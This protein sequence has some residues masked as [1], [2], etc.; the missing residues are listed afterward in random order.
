MSDEDDQKAGFA[1]EIGEVRRRAMES[2]HLFDLVSSM[3]SDAKRA[4]IRFQVAVVSYVAV[5][6]P[7]RGDSPKFETV[8]LYPSDQRTVTLESLIAQQG[9][10]EQRQ[11]TRETTFGTETETVVE[12]SLLPPVVLRNAV[13]TLN[14]I[15]RDLGFMPEP[16]AKLPKGSLKTP[17]PPNS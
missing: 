13:H 6:F 8:N 4:H 11:V 16:D 17:E 9:A 7:Y 1:R 10:A 14:E 12:P 2:M 5:L 15:A 3:D